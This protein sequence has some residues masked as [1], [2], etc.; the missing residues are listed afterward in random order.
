MLFACVLVR[1]RA[2]KLASA[3]EIQMRIRIILICIGLVLVGTRVSCPIIV[4][5]NDSYNTMVLYKIHH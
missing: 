1:V 3:L 4:H 2:C 5:Y